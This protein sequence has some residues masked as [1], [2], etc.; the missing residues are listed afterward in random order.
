MKNTTHRKETDMS[1]IVY[2]NGEFKPLDEAYVH[3]EDRG[4]N[5]A[6]ALYEVAR[7]YNGVP[8]TLDRH[9]QRMQRGAEQIELDCMPSEEQFTEIVDEL[10]RRNELKEAMAYIQVSRGRAPR[11]HPFPPSS[12]PTVFV[13]VK[14]HQPVSMQ[15]RLEGKSA[16]T[17]QDLRYAF[18]DV[19]TTALLPNVLACQKAR[20]QGAYESI[21]IRQG[22]VTEGS[23]TNVYIVQDGSLLTHPLVNILPGIT[24]SVVAELCV[25]GGIPFC[26]EVF[27]PKEL[28]AADEVFITGSVSEIVPIVEVDG[29]SI[30]EG[31]TGPL[32]RRLINLYAARVRK[33]CGAYTPEF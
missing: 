13:M 6:D 9:L 2:L 17:M 22:R 21:L 29:C 11:D 3:V 16:I 14:P 23:N 18:C 4:F 27:T 7:V 19:K 20:E 10:L 30:G 12:E 31:E 15:E 24:R 5:F 33:D 25:E 1:R 26:E 8:F 28:M 32:T